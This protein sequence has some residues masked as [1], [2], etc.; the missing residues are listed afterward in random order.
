LSISEL[1][2]GHIYETDIVIEYGV[3]H[4]KPIR[5]HGASGPVLSGTFST[6]TTVLYLRI[7]GKNGQSFA[8]LAA[9]RDPAS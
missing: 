1:P 9:L 7:R 2:S 8:R 4:L 3:F 6:N 5:L